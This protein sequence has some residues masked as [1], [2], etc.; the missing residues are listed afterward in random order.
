MRVLRWT[1]GA[2]VVLGLIVAGYVA[3]LVLQPGVTDFAGGTAV[4]L[5]AY[6][7]P[8]PT[9]TPADLP[10]GDALSRGAYLTA[11]ADCAACHTA[12]GGVPFAGGR[13]FKLPFGTIYTPNLTPDRETG[14]GNWSDAEFLR[15]VHK[16]I[17]KGGEH[18]YPA[19]PYASYTMLTDADVLAIKAYLFSLAPVHQAT[20]PNTF[21]FP[22]NQRWLMAIWSTL[23]NKDERFRPRPAQ[24]PVWN[25]GA[26]LVEAAG[27]CAE[28]HSPRNL[29]QAPDT[30]QKMAGGQAEGWNAYNI[31]SDRLSGIGA[32]ST[33]EVTDYLT[34]GHAAGRGTAS[35]PMREAVELSLTKL[36]RGD[37]AAI[38]TYL[39]TV[40]AIRSSASPEPTGPA[41]KLASAGPSDN[42]VGKRIFEGACTSCHAWTGAGALVGQAQLTGGR[43]VNDP[44]ATNVAQMVLNGS[45][46][47]TS[48]HPVMPG[49]AS[50][51][52][53]TEIAAVANYVTARFGAVPSKV[54]A[55]E[56]TRLREQN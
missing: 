56:V 6:T 7:G 45:G 36:T 18:L 5:A 1:F 35:G 28:C 39:R 50:A 37:I 26:Y 55:K 14:I 32:W 54:T 46:K 3:W 53:D 42:P 11:A 51:Y 44:S 43:A 21:G 4:D 9:G 41:P 23:F 24:S 30:R 47:A 20:P 2:I 22:F 17:G 16:G 38:V 29:M 19:F 8:S 12:K 13:P 40:P 15:A 49:F 48:G 27:H 31:T 25:R 52:T 34:K 10:Q 33:Q